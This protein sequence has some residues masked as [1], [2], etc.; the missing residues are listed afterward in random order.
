MTRRA[1][2]VGPAV[3]WNDRTDSVLGTVLEPHRIAHAASDKCVWS[4]A[5]SLARP[6]AEA[7][8]PGS[9]RLM[10]SHVLLQEGRDLD[11][12]EHALR[13]VLT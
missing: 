1:F 11:T 3:L 12:A 13:D 9:L 4:C 10:L 6:P 7:F 8:W 2:S 5:T